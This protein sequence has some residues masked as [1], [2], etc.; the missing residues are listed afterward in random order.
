MKELNTQCK[1]EDRH[2]REAQSLSF[3]NSKKID[4]P[5]ENLLIGKK[6]KIRKKINTRSKRR[7]KL[8]DQQ[9]GKKE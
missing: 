6:K 3:E 7:T 9:K 5:L 8:Q 2:M 1:I 4:N